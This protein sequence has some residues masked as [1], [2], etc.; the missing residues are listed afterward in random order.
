M[1]VQTVKKACR[2]FLRYQDFDPEEE[3]NS[4]FGIGD[5]LLWAIVFNR[6]ELAEICWQRGKDHLFTGLICSVFLK[7]FSLEVRNIKEDV[8]ADAL[9]EHSKIF[10]QR[11]T[12]IL[13]KMS[14]ENTNQALSL[15]QESASVWGIYSSPLTFAYE[16]WIYDLV[17]HTCVRKYVQKYYF[18]PKEKFADK[19]SSPKTRFILTF[20]TY[21]IGLLFYSVFVLTSTGTEYFVEGGI[22]YIEYIVYIWRFGDILE[23]SLGCLKYTWKKGCSRLHWK[24]RMYNYLTFW[25][26]LDWLSHF[27]LVLALFLRY[28]SQSEGQIY[29]RN[30]YAISL[31]FIYLRFLEIYLMLKGVGTTVIMIKEML[32]DL[33]QFVYIIL[34]V[35]SG[36]GI[37]YHAN[38]WPDHQTMWSGRL[39]DWRIWTILLHPYWQIFG[40]VDLEYLTGSNQDNCSSNRSI[41]QADPS[42]ERCPQQDLTVQVIAG[43]Y[44]MFTNILLVNIIIARFSNT[45]ERIQT[46]SE[47]IWYYHIYTVVID[48]ADWV[49]SPFNL[50]Y[51]PLNIICNR[52]CIRKIADSVEKTKV[53]EYQQTLQR[54]VALRKHVKAKTKAST[55]DSKLNASNSYPSTIGKSTRHRV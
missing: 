1:F 13:D 49:P 34:F 38:L 50:I 32:K 21:I 7:T 35:V 33:V 19:I 10:E 5:V 55:V 43:L 9:E 8:L 42:K 27:T 45:F 2:N 17:A 41:W 44:M 22:Q 51:H 14:D 16:N 18:K 48:Y 23:E 31:L 53:K 36:V 4:D 28:V 12:Y 24:R 20:E 54:T 40:E 25:N 30:M 3:E 11:C 39:S 52:S 47:K 26:V 37:Y 29:A 15:L 6:R 46:D